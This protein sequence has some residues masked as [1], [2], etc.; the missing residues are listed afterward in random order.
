VVDGGAVI[1]VI[2]EKDL[3]RSTVAAAMGYGERGR[4]ALLRTLLV[5]EVMSEPAVTIAPQ[6]A[7]RDAAEI[8]LHRR[9]GCLP[10]VEG[11]ALVG[12]VTQTD[13]LRAF[14]DR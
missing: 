1:G 9:I 3:L 4:K 14:V 5:K 11:G 10:V 2:S 12:L 6:I 8:M 7:A 13:L